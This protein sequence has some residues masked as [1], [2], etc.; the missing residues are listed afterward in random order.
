MENYENIQNL[1]M[2]SSNSRTDTNPGSKT[3]ALSN[4]ADAMGEEPGRRYVDA[5]GAYRAL[6]QNFDDLSDYEAVSWTIRSER[7]MEKL[8]ARLNGWY[9][10]F[11]EYTSE[12]RSLGKAATHFIWQS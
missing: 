10:L 6:K 3:A 4:A 11:P 8:E 9:A 2:P 7:R 1:N 12:K 5:R